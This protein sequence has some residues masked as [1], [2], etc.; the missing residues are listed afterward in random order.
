MRETPT[1]ALVERM[2]RAEKEARERDARRI[3]DAWVI[4]A[5]TGMPSRFIA[6]DGRA[7]TVT[8]DGRAAYSA[9]HE[10]QATPETA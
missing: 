5:T 6:E 4:A 1:D 10:R 8:P 7:V 9:E 2:A 3:E